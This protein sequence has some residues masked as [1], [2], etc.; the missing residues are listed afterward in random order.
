MLVADKTINVELKDY[1]EK[2]EPNYKELRFVKASSAYLYFE[3]SE[4]ETDLSN[5]IDK[6]FVCWDNHHYYDYQIHDV[7]IR[8]GIYEMTNKEAFEKF[9]WSERYLA[10]PV[11]LSGSLEFQVGVS[12]SRTL[13]ATAPSYITKDE[14]Y[15]TTYGCCFKDIYTQYD[16][17]RILGF[18][19]GLKEINILFNEKVGYLFKDKINFSE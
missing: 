8:I 9:N 2:G 16:P 10:I 3:L 12:Y 7:L 19:Y 17:E 18:G 4:D 15:H 13:K 14:Q 11:G 6:R 5:F 1:Y